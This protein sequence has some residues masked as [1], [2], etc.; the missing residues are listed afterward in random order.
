MGIIG[1]GL[2]FTRIVINLIFIPLTSLPLISTI[3][4]ILLAIGGPLQLVWYALVGRKLL[5][6]GHR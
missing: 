1:H 2:D 5:Q 6:L 3:G 4:F